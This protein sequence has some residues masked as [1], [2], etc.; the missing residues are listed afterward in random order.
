MSG[1][2]Q[3]ERNL[4]V[5]TEQ[6]FANHKVH[7]EWLRRIEGNYSRHLEALSDKI[8]LIYEY[9]DVQEKHSSPKTYLEKREGVKGV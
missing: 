3:L 6:Y 1:I 7:Q 2:K 4:R 5:L 8:S 9:L